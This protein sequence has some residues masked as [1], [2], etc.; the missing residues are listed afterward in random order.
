MSDAIA[1]EITS[2]EASPQRLEE[3]RA[4]GLHPLAER[5]LANRAEASERSPA[6][7]LEPTL[8]VLDHPDSLPDIDR[9]AERIA[10]AIINAECIAI[11]TDHDVDGVT[12]HALIYQALTQHFAH[13]SDRIQGFI[14]LR[15]KEGYG[16]SDSLAERMIDEHPRA[17]L[18][19]T[20]DNGSSD[21][22][23][24]ERLAAAGMDVVV[25]DHHGMPEQ[26]AP[27]AAYACI[28]PARDDSRYPDGA[29]AGVMVAWL[30][31][32]RVRTALIHAGHLPAQAPRLGDLIDFV[33]LGTVAD[34]VSMGSSLNN[35]AVVRAG[36][37]RMQRMER[38]CWRAARAWMGD[39]AEPI[40]AE[41]LG[42]ALG[43]RVNAQGR[44][45]DALVAV[46][47][48]LARSDEQ[49]QAQAKVLEAANQSRR[50]IQESLR[51]EAFFVASA[52]R[53]VGRKGLVIS[54]VE[55]HPGVHGIVA[56]KIVEALGQPVVCFSPS[57]TDASKLTGSCRS[58]GGVHIR[59]ALQAVSE[60]A[61]GGIE[62]FGGHAGAGGLLIRREALA[63]FEK[64]F[65]EA[66]RAQVGEAS[67][68]PVIETDGEVDPAAIDQALLDD[69][70]RLE[71]YGRGFDGARF[72]ASFTLGKAYPMGKAGVH[73]KLT[74]RG[75][76][77]RFEGVWFNVGESLPVAVG[78]SAVWVFEPQANHWQGR[79]RLQLRVIDIER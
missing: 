37:E 74:L 55:G 24:I 7:L 71:P 22:P 65:D 40:R 6:A 39:E 12:A 42:F 20:A 57:L 73:W 23:R 16:I 17:S 45:D 38:P 77:K 49:A 52:Q 54:L 36:I 79:K 75:G 30:L 19:I 3:A 44:L 69:L 4:L 59:Q 56:S 67:L 47:F 70:A 68:R 51:D 63:D 46:R 33:A 53:E 26:G 32:V 28:S 41:T 13:P 10:D 48:L 35:R 58:D 27:P 2:R 29:I 72:S 8:T 31:M 25:T 76:G 1:P 21:A 15:L 9:G 62:R 14:G 34:C 11:E 50:R 64:A 61:R 5:V 18:V 66:V 43:P 78:E 60:S